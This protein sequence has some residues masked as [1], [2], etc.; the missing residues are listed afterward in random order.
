MRPHLI[1]ST[2]LAVGL[3]PAVALA[4]PSATK[5]YKAVLLGS[6]VVPKQ[7]PARGKGTARFTVSGLKLCWK[8]TVSGIDTPVAAHI[9]RG[10]ALSTGPVIVALGRHFKPIGC[11]AMSEDAALAIGA[12]NCGGVYVDV[13]TKKFHKGAIRGTLEARR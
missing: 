12:C 8:I 2:V 6:N 11:A 9:H 5:T 10:T 13:H 1:I 3:V 4:S 7:G